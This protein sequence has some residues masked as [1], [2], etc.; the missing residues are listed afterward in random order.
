MV[1]RPIGFC[2]DYACYDSKQEVGTRKIHGSVGR[3]FESLDS[4]GSG[5]G[6]VG[7]E[8]LSLSEGLGLGSDQLLFT[9]NVVFFTRAA[10]STPRN[11]VVWCLVKWYAC[12][13]HLCLQGQAPEGD[14]EENRPLLSYANFEPL[15]T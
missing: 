12:C 10:V 15:R 9:A 6:S 4:G 8:P 3:P 11:A 5:Q 1:R 13:C 2:L 7:R 14:A